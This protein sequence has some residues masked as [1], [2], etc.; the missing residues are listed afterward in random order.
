ME[1]PNDVGG[2]V[3]DRDK[4]VRLAMWS[5]HFRGASRQLGW[6]SGTLMLAIE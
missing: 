1:R 6:V 5:S 2:K 4:R 3:V